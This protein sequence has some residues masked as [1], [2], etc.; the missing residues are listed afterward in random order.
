MVSP[1]HRGIG[2]L[3]DYLAL[4]NSDEKDPV[5]EAGPEGSMVIGMRR[6]TFFILFLL[7]ALVVQGVSGTL[8]QW[9]DSSDPNDWTAT[10]ADGRE[11]SSVYD[12]YYGYGWGR[13]GTVYLKT[14]SGYPFSYAAWTVAKVGN[15]Y[16]NRV[17]FYDINGQW[18]GSQLTYTSSLYDRFEIY[19]VG[20]EYKLYKNGEYLS[21]RSLGTTAYYC[22]IGYYQS[23]SNLVYIYIDDA[24]LGNTGTSPKNIVTTCPDEW[25]VA[26]DLIQPESF[27]GLYTAYDTRRSADKMSVSYAT[28]AASK[29]IEVKHIATN[30]IVDS[31]ST[32]ATQYA[33]YIQYNLTEM[34]FNSG[35]P[36][37]QYSV[38]IVGASEPEASD[39]FTYK[40]IVTTGTTIEWDNTTYSV[41][42]TALMEYSI[43]EQYWVPESYTYK[44]SVLDQ[45]FDEVEEW[46]ITERPT[47]ESK[48]TTISETN[49]PYSG[50]YYACLYAV[51][52]SSQEEILLEFDEAYIDV[53]WNE[54]GSVTIE[55]ETYDAVT[56]SVLGSCTV[57]ATQRGIDHIT[58]SDMDGAYSIS[59][60]ITMKSI[61]V[62]PYKD[63]YDGYSVYFTPYVSG[64]YEVDLPL[65]P[66][67]G[68]EPGDWYDVDGGQVT[69]INHSNETVSYYNSTVDGTSLG[70]ISYLA[71]YWSAGEDVSCTLSNTTWNNT[72]VC[73]TGGWYQWNNLDHTS[74]YTLSCEKDGYQTVS[75][76]CSLTEGCFN[77]Q[78]AYLGSDFTLT[79]NVKDLDSGAPLAGHSVT[80]TLSTG[81]ET[82]TETGTA[83]FENVPYGVID[84]DTTA[85]GYYPGASSIVMDASKSATVYMQVRPETTI[86]PVVPPVY[87][88]HQVRFVVQDNFGRPLEGVNITA[89][90]IEASTPW[91]WIT[92]LLGIESTEDMDI[93]NTTLSGT[94]GTDG[95][96]TT[97][98]VESVK[99]RMTFTEEDL[100]INVVRDLYPKEDEYV[101]WIR[102][103]EVVNASAYPDYLV[104][105]EDVDIDTVAIKMM[106]HDPGLGT[107]DL[108]YYILDSDGAIVHTQSWSPVT[109]EYTNHSYNLDNV[110]GEQYTFGFN[111]THEDY[112]EISFWKGITMK[113]T[114]LLVDLGFE[115]SNWYMWIS[116]CIVFIVGG[117]FHIST[118]KQGVIVTPLMAGLFWYIGWLPA[119][120]GGFIGL[121]GALGVL[122]HMRKQEYKTG[123]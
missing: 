3:L 35:A 108:D 80:V 70:G 6:S 16:P 116:L 72:Q 89:Q 57:T 93:Q 17:Q 66:S 79:V 8:W 41:Y 69:V 23:A 34:L 87:A 85:L 83:T 50:Y 96:W 25:W 104:W 37:G 95:S 1:D 10:N 4:E 98:M 31:R 36:Y 68:A 21:S 24:I 55:G 38:Y 33:G 19:L 76:S 94:T 12:N 91:S 103:R 52:R 102:L 5:H 59:E 51:D 63:G 44:V 115:D 75:T 64:T 46:V 121:A 47:S 112:G 39:T 65:V 49:Y 123:R 20:T 32:S 105:A 113:G 106:Y 119:W 60:L 28:D 67:G 61:G 15:G 53:S 118:V 82:A 42:D 29:T 92:N 18:I 77:R 7:V 13:S 74:T 54:I 97:I 90:A 14:V 122:I 30:E 84:I 88:G 111:A 100:G 48:S 9:E 117:C 73:D 101:I 58:S 2:H 40:S 107:T 109:T 27:S 71:P 120:I 114:G 86:A 56:G 81:A 22:A 78:D 45:G 43:S 110:K 11:L 26:K 62:S 99:Y